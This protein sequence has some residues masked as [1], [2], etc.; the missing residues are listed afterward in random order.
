MSP[1]TEITS[2]SD[3]EHKKTFTQS[4]G[5]YDLKQRKN[6]IVIIA[7]LAL[8]FL[9]ACENDAGIPEQ[10][11]QAAMLAHTQ[12][13]HLP[14]VPAIVIGLDEDM[15]NDEEQDETTEHEDEPD[16]PVAERVAAIVASMTLHEKICQLLIVTLD[17]ITGVSGPTTA[18]EAARAALELYPVGGLIHFSPNITSTEQI[19]SLNSALQG[20]SRVPLFLAVDEEGGSVARLGNKL[21]AH[22]VRAMLTYEG[23]GEEAAFENAATI[24]N[25][26]ISHGFNTNFAPVADV[27]SNPANSV[28]GNRAFSRD[29]DA[30]A[31]LVAAA[32]R[33][34]REH[35]IA[36]SLKH[37][38]GHGSTREDSHHRAA[39][40]NKTLDE[41]RDNEFK[42]FSAGIAAG[43]D[44]V[45]LGHLI[46]PD[47]DELPA[48]LSRKLITDVLRGELGF[49]GVVIT[50]SL[51]MDAIS[52]QFSAEF[53]AITAI[54]A[55]V[56]ILLMPANVSETVT[57]LVAAVESGDI[58]ECRIDESV[59]R[60]IRLKIAMG[61]YAENLQ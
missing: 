26:L 13:A 28:I 36:C 10:V 35:S 6:T 17:S 60:I 57:A 12:P 25:A 16:D 47:I 14:E 11:E 7:M 24:S 43:A 41:L 8:A 40:V 55:G 44:M 54:N 22:S 21:G 52:R 23:G 5:T 49:D 39:F 30:A 19:S 1:I 42:P 18:G 59:S 58:P 29:F 56:D 9:C 33:S 31:E 61:I 38:P 20:Y 32:V 53:V 46:V 50:D 51:V 48:T 2:R 3:R 34:F 15:R 37:F 27:W 4:K 45:M